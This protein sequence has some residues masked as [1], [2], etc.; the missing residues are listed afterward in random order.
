MLITAKEITNFVKIK[1]KCSFS[2]IITEGEEKEGNANVVAN[3]GWY[4]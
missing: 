3:N 1:K 4:V 2:N